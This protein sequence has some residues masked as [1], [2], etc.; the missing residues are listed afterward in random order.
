[1]KNIWFSLLTCLCILPLKPVPVLHRLDGTGLSAQE[2]TDHIK[3]LMADAHV[4]GMAVSVFNNNDPVYTQVF[5]Y[6]D[7]AHQRLLDAGSEWWACSFSKAVFAYFV[8]KCVDKG[9]I[10][11]DTPLV[12]YLKKPL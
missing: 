4:T 5:G 6:A 8:M 3:K 2:L 7:A 10:Q 9:I 1:M 11:L 12:H